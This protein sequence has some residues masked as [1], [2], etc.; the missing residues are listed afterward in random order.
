ML[1]FL[2]D[3]EVDYVGISFVDSADHVRAVRKEIGSGPTRIIAKIENRGGLSNVDEICSVADAIMIDRGDLAVETSLEDV[4]L[5]QKRI[6]SA[7]GRAGRPVIVATEMLH[8]MVEGEN[9]TKAE[10]SDITNAVLDGCAATML[11]GETAVGVNPVQAVRIMRGVVDAADKYLQDQLNKESRLEFDNFPQAIENAAVSICRSLP[12]TKIVAI[13]RSGYA[14]TLLASRQLSQPILGVS[15]DRIAARRFNLLP[16]VA[17]VHVDM[18]FSKVSLDHVRDC[19]EV[20]WR[21]GLIDDDD[22]VLVVAVGYPKSGT[23]MNLLQ[24]HKIADLNS[25]FGWAR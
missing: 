25:L 13:T 14:A 2:A 18:R 5:S 9:P 23:R 17:G 11:S 19:L 20:L 10:I 3:N 12:V 15:D 21:D 22:L 7:A 6:L 4:A 8:S 1:R 24:T 16:G